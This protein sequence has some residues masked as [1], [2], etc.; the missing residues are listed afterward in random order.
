MLYRV[1]AKETRKQMRATGIDP[2]KVKFYD[3]G[4]QTIS[5]RSF[6]S[7]YG[8]TNLYRDVRNVQ[9]V[10]NVEEKLSRLEGIAATTIQRLHQS[11]EESLS[12]FVLT[13]DETQNLRRFLFIMHYRHAQLSTSYFD[14]AHPDNAIGKERMIRMQNDLGLHTSADMWLHFLEYYLDTPHSSLIQHGAQCMKT[15]STKSFIAHAPLRPDL[16]YF[17]AVPYLQQ[18]DGYYLG[19]WK[20]APG[21]EFVLGHKSFGIYEGTAIPPLELHKVFVVSPQITMILRS[22]ELRAESMEQ[23]RELGS[24]VRYFSDLMNI[25]LPP[26]STHYTSGVPHFS[27]YTPKYEMGSP[28]W[29]AEKALHFLAQHNPD[30]KYEFPITT[31]TPEQTYAVNRIVLFNTESTGSITYSS[32]ASM[33]DTASRYEKDPRII[34]QGKG[35]KFTSLIRQLELQVSEAEKARELEDFIADHHL[36]K[37]SRRQKG[38]KAQSVEHGNLVKPM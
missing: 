19:F 37:W 32:D 34:L 23:N 14:P 38:D 11:V 4:E 16:E 21:Q 10:N 27:G 12:S 9:N 31:L 30:D 25:R 1:S 24:H 33:L 6:G 35:R 15:M 7:V 3:I 26:A 5:E 20:A 17:E 28:A 36:E 13:R 8:V 22:V 2:R 18:S 29:Q